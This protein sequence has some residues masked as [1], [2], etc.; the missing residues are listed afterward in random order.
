[1]ADRNGS[2][3]GARRAVEVAAPDWDV[4]A[5]G[6]HIVQFYESEVS[7][8]ESVETF[9]RAG[10]DAGEG[11]VV[12][13]TAEH[14]RVL[15]AVLEMRG[16]EL[17][18]LRRAGRLVE[19]DATELLSAVMEGGKP[20]RA[21]FRG[22]IGPLVERAAGGGRR[23]RA[24][25][26]LVALL[27]IAG[28]H[29]AA[30]ALEDLWEELVAERGIGLLC[31]YPLRSF[32]R[33]QDGLALSRV[34]ERHRRVVPAESYRGMASGEQRGR[35]IAEL[36]QRSVALEQELVERRAL[37]EALQ[38][39]N[40]ELED[41][42]RE[43]TRELEETHRRLRFNDRM[44]GLGALAVG[45]GHDLG[46][47]LMPLRLRL[48]ALSRVAPESMKGDLA[49]ISDTAQYLERL[50]GALRAL[51]VEGPGGVDGRGGST[52]LAW[53]AAEVS[54]VLRGLVPRGARLEFAVAEGLPPVGMDAQRL[55]HVAFNLVQ[56]ACEAMGLWGAAVVRVE[57]RGAE[58][59]GGGVVLCV[60]DNGP[61]M[62]PE[63]LR[64]CLDPYFTTKT[65]AGSTGLGLALVR[66]MVE[67]AGGSIRVESE[68]GRGAAFTIELP[69]A[70][71][72]GGARSGA[73]EG[74]GGEANGAVNGLA[75]GSASGSANG[76]VNGSGNGVCEG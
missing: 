31:A 48:A 30:V 22:A 66:S 37:Q 20:D 46:N 39:L 44:Q 17:P 61:G 51:S 59:A 57:A 67:S 15:E 40:A 19:G 47:L 54:P 38:A 50:V 65:R 64:R 4:V 74:A 5:D 62:S 11:V 41:R 72:G 32:G 35:A 60:R 63:V 33:S 73:A 42:V 53:W 70:G 16:H 43:R 3:S 7:L 71:G 25:G 23:V 14:R 10:L 36:Q 56:N 12:L 26:E 13:A 76:S 29:E 49:A 45:L 52:D 21:R 2:G 34:C 24:F 69:A 75:N 68:L 58:G 6:D 1:M 27:T 55:T 28:S 9:V 8:I 18:A